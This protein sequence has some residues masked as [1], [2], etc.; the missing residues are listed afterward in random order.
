MKLASVHFSLILLT[1]VFLSLGSN[2]VIAQNIDDAIERYMEYADDESSIDEAVET[3]S[4]LIDTPILLNDSTSNVPEWLLT[5]LQHNL[6]R[7]YIMQHGYI[8]SWEELELVNGFDSVTISQLKNYCTLEKPYFAKPSLKNMLSQG[9][10]KLLVG[11]SNT[12]EKA[13]GYSEDIYEG[14]PYRLYARYKYNFH[15]ILSIQLSAEKDAGEAFFNGSL[16]QG[17]DHYSGHIMLNR[18]GIIKSA[19]VGRYRLQFGQGLTLWSGSKAFLGW[20]ATGMRHGRGICTA[21]PFSEY[22]YLQGTAVTISL[23]KGLEATAFYSYTRLDATLD[24]SSSFAYSISKTGYHRYATEINKRKKLGEHLFGGNLQWNRKSLHLGVTAIHNRYS[25]PL[26]P[27]DYVYNTHAFRGQTLTDAGIDFSLR[28]RKIMLFGEGSVSSNGG[29]AALV[30]TD[31][32]ISTNTTF[33]LIYRNYAIN[34]YNQHA[35]TWGRTSL[36][37]NESGFRF[38]VQTILPLRVQLLLQADLYKHPAMR[39]RCYGPSEGAD[40]RTELT[41]T[42]ATEKSSRRTITVRASHHFSNFMRNDNETSRK[43]YVVST[44]NRHIIYTDIIY[45]TIRLSLRSRIGYSHFSGGHSV[46][47]NGVALAEDVAVQFGELNIGGRIALFDIGSYDGRMYVAERGLEYDNGGTSLYGKGMRFYLIAKYNCLADHLTFA[48]KYS[49]LAFVDRNTVGS[50]YEL[51]NSP[52]KQQL[53]LQIRY[54][55]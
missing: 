33:S 40:I 21:S 22:D 46:A 45:Q 41:R 25:M 29:I 28:A 31:I 42:F 7:A 1:A 54:N 20:T 49:V 53:R 9:H 36:P 4:D 27:R 51:I 12:F 6:L 35:S 24:T 52:H 48:L 18:V 10:N 44:Y 13:R 14:K 34:Y 26:H 47:A 39:Y 15:D 17:F 23:P 3:Y 16:K 38:A 32:F 55:W 30:G 2:D 50:G 8:V 37:N 11:F 5:P 43:E 19:V